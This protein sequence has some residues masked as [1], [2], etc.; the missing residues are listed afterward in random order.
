MVFVVILKP[1]RN[2]LENCLSIWQWV[3]VNI[4]PFEGFYKSFRH[5]VALR[6][7][8]RCEAGFKIELPGKDDRFLGCI[9]RDEAGKTIH[10]SNRSGNGFPYRGLMK[11]LIN[12][13]QGK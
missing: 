7:F 8:D 3:N 2:E 6:A 4:I 1:L 10:A 9:C 11:W 13:E 5:P 12:F